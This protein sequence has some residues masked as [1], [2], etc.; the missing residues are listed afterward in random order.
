MKRFFLSVPI[1]ATWMDVTVRDGRDPLTEED[2]SS[3]LVA[4][5]TV[6]LLPHQAYR[7]A[8]KQKYFNL[9]PDETTVTSIRV[10][11]GI[12]C[13]L[14]LARYWSAA[15]CTKVNA[16]VQFRG[17]WPVPQELQMVCG[18]G[19]S[20]VRMESHVKDESINPSAKLTKWKTPL[21]PKSEG[22]MSPMGEDR[23]V[24]P[25]NEKRIYQLVLTYE[26]KQEEAGSITP[27]APSL[28]GVL[29]ESAF[30][31]QLMMI[32]DGEKKYL[33]V[34]D[35]WPSEVKVPKGTVT[36]RLQIRHDNVEMLEKLKDM[37][38]WI[39]RKMEKDIVLSAY[40][41]KEAMMIG[42]DTMKK[43]I[44]RKGTTAAVFFAEPPPSK[45]PSGCKCGD[46]LFGTANFAAGDGALPGDGKCPG[47]FPISFVVGPKSD[48]KAKD[49]GVTPEVPDERGVQEKLADAVRD[50][51]VGQLEKLTEKEKEDGK[52]DELY[53][54]LEKE[55]P[56]H[57][58][59][60]MAALKHFDTSKARKD[61]LQQIVDAA[62]KVLQLISED[63]LAL[64]FGK[65]H[66]KEDPKSCKVSFDYG[67][68]QRWFHSIANNNLVLQM[69]RSCCSG[70]QGNGGE[71]SFSCGSSGEKSQG[72]F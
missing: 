58:P 33:G 47:G 20:Q 27:R 68:F 54:V 70:T 29:Y 21:R 19:G 25:S 43:R 65:S 14:D 64:H 34:A 39:E 38:I 59:L 23:D 67:Q 69:S 22:V 15:G 55:Y 49:N 18:G 28:Q 13:E 48:S 3:R 44:L 40:V 72:N 9:L 71:E 61:G 57:I 62:D 51:K 1:G 37:A 30:E 45:I 6:Q 10:H 35:S 16:S 17:V 50:L 36:I 53:N 32:F 31:S 56:E 5:H 66:D 41:S 42:K 46:V 8:E 12:T 26:F 7:D 63:E 60:L 52:F 4:L 2:S 24:L 11:S